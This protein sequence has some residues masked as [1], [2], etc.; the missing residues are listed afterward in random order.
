MFNT[1]VCGFSCTSFP[2]DWAAGALLHPQVKIMHTLQARTGSILITIKKIKKNKSTPR[3]ALHSCTAGEDVHFLGN[4][5][6]LLNKAAVFATSCLSGD[7]SRAAQVLTSK[8]QPMNLQ[9]Q[10][11][12]QLL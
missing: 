8:S 12:C 11:Q 4:W 5:A 9:Q 1:E 7:V 6:R 2:L 10:H 3:K